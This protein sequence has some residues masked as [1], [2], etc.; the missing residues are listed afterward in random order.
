MFIQM[1]S[2][3]EFKTKFNLLK[4]CRDGWGNHPWWWITTND[5]YDL[6]SR[7]FQSWMETNDNVVCK[8]PC[9]SLK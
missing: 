9:G 8:Y 1:K 3:K 2:E 7:E 5:G 4:R 6:I